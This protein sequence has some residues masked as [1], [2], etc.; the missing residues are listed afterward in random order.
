MRILLLLRGSAGCGKSTWIKNNGLKPYALSADEIRLMCQAPVMQV[1]GT[2]QISQ[3]NDKTVWSMLFKILEVRMQHGEFTVID[4]TN[5]KTSEINQYKEL[6]DKYRYRLYCVDFTDIPIEETKRRN[7]NREEYKRVPEEAIDKFYSRFDT[8]K[9]PSGVQV[10]KPDELDKIWMKKLDFSEY[11]KIHHIGDI[12]GCYTVLQ[13]YLN[14]NGGIKDDEFYIFLGDYIDRG[15]ENAEVLKFLL[16]IVNKKNVLLLEGNHERWL[17]TYGNDLPSKSKEFELIT[18]PKLEA[19]GIDKKDMRKLYRRFAQC[20]YYQYGEKIFIVTHGGIS[21]VPNNFTLL[22]T[23][24]MIKGVGNYNDVEDVANSFISNTNDST[25]QIFGHRNTKSLPIQINE[26]VFNLEGNVEFGGNLRC[27]Q[28]D[29]DGIHTFETKN[30][31]FK[32]QKQSE[33][34]STLINSPLSDIITKLRNNKYVV[35]KKFGNI[36]SF[37]FSK[38][39][40]Q[41]KIWDEQTIHA[42]GLFIDTNKGKIVARSYN[43]FF[44]INER[45]E[46]KLDSLSRTLKFPVTVYVKEN[47]FLGMVSYNEYEDNLFITTKSCPD[48]AAA[49]YLRNMFYNSTTEETRNNLKEFLRSNNVTLVFECVD[50]EN[51]PHVIEYS[52]SKLYL[53]DVVYNDIKFRKYSYNDMCFVADTFGFTNK[54][55]AFEIETWQEFFDWY[56][57]VL[58]PDYKYNGRIIEGF[59][60]EDISGYMIKLKLSY[61]NFWKFMRSIAHSVI[62]SGNFKKTSA[63]LTPLANEFYG[64]TKT[65][66]K[67]ENKENIPDDICNLRK[68]FYEY[69]KNKDGNVVD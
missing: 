67:L 65:L 23:E 61:Y 64:W 48:G 69:K 8:Q 17:Y 49:E 59:V 45:P 68:M 46:T 37:N 5:S 21:S 50:M 39:A 19:A 1:D 35:E 40:F 13:E 36:S 32:T 25:Y 58:K 10:I 16:S 4:A 27:I 38:K 51:D 7:K 33:E 14:N 24:Q 62:K 18:K 60:I 56:Y 42:R 20:A 22:A 30:T 53:L 11:K 43:K 63:L 29:V 52:E 9:I 44:S 41:N 34:N 57:E 47:G 26:R 3:N 66:Y 15:S 31:V 54:E 6:C 12:H 2:K 28:V 55:K